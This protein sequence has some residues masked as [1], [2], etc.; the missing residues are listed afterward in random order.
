MEYKNLL[1]RAQKSVSKNSGEERFKMP[2]AI[3]VSAGKTTTIKNFSYIANVLR[4]K[5]EHIAKFFFKEL[6]I[7]GRIEENKLILGQN[8]DQKTIERII[9]NYCNEFVFCKE[10]GKADSKLVKRGKLTFLKCEA[11]GAERIVKKI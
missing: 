9:K 11:C 8:F 10:C 7:P 2:E 4:R 6:A 3:V 5:P 1:E